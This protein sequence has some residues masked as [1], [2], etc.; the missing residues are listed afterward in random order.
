VDTVI[1]FGDVILNQG[2]GYDPQTGIFTAP[3]DGLYSFTWAFLTKKGGTIYF[4][5]MVDNETKVRSCVKNLQ[6]DYISTSGHLLYDLKKGSQV[7]IQTFYLQATYVHA[8]SYTYFS[9]HRI[10]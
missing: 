4:S 7:W 8:N 9:G 2:G 5:A 6:D 10:N 3:D 1:S